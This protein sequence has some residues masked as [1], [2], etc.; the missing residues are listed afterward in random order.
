[1]TN[2]LLSHQNRRRLDAE[3]LR[4]ALLSVSGLLD[5]RLGG[6]LLELENAAYVTNDQSKDAARYDTPRRSIYLPIIRN[7]MLDL[8][9]AFDYPDPSMTVE[10]RP[11]TTSPIQAL[12]LMNSPLVL[13][14]S[15]KLAKSAVET[16][17][18]GRERVRFLY[19]AA[20]G[21]PPLAEETERAL[22]FI[23]SQTSPREDERP[24]AD[25]G[26]ASMESGERLS[27]ETV[28]W[29]LFAQVLLVS[30]EFLFVE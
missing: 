26:E 4:D 29:S 9:S 6:S 7:A 11:S 2:R 5:A 25:I 30:N 8:F 17:S 12:Y 20:H 22:G 10:Q 18:D 23:A 1:P 14:V 28:A 3:Q 16:S 27:R 24:R 19:L 13:Q 21:R 15:A